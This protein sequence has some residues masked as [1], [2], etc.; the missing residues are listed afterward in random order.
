MLCYVVVGWPTPARYRQRSEPNH[1]ACKMAGNKRTEHQES[2]RVFGPAGPHFSRP[3]NHIRNVV[4]VDVNH[5]CLRAKYHQNRELRDRRGPRER[6]R[7]TRNC[8]MFRQ[9]GEPSDVAQTARRTRK[10]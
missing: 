2:R 9:S 5:V 1:V 8:N 4:M 7:D 6:P 3:A 10:H